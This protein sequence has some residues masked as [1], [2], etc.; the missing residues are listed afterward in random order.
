MIDEIRF[1]C[2]L[3]IDVLNIIF[4]SNLNIELAKCD[5]RLKRIDPNP[6]VSDD[7]LSDTEFDVDEIEEPST[8][9]CEARRYGKFECPNCDR[10]WGSAF[11]SGSNMFISGHKYKFYHIQKTTL[12]STTKSISRFYSRMFWM[13]R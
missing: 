5:G 7:N 2:I 9:T 1:V 4:L 8:F 13:W 3:R 12:Y 11:G 6:I 10:K